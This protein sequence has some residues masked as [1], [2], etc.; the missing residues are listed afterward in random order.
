METH[1]PKALGATRET[2]RRN[3]RRA[4]TRHTVAAGGRRHPVIEIDARGFVIEADGRPPLRGFVDLLE[5]DRLV[6]R[7]LVVCAWAREGL[8]GYEFKRDT[9]GRPVAPDHVP[10]GHAGL[11]PPPGD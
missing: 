10:P 9:G 3:L 8:V 6:D 11:L 5:D 2:D 4:R 7:R 1:L